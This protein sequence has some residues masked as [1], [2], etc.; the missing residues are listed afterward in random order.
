MWTFVV[1]R[2][3]L[4]HDS[5]IFSCMDWILKQKKYGSFLPISPETL[6]L[7]CSQWCITTSSHLAHSVVFPYNLLSSLVIS[8]GSQQLYLHHPLAPA[9][10]LIKLS[11]EGNAE[12]HSSDLTSFLL[13]SQYDHLYSVMSNDVCHSCTDKA[14]I[15]CSSY[16]RMQYCSVLDTAQATSRPVASVLVD[17][18][19]DRLP[20]H[21]GPHRFP[22]F[23]TAERQEGDNW[24][25]TI[26]T[27]FIVWLRIMFIFLNILIYKYFWF[28]QYDPFSVSSF[29]CSSCLLHPKAYQYSAK[30]WFPIFRFNYT[31]MGPHDAPGDVVLEIVPIQ[32]AS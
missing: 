29:L 16:R 9:S 13:I 21:C 24:M 4:N 14:V 23:V 15:S 26:V 6:I 25:D 22:L 31:D 2:C 11:P 18:G 27:L 3:I 17:A 28:L 8:G 30:P 12:K 1:F 20:W 19:A 10:C 7:S 32:T 5:F